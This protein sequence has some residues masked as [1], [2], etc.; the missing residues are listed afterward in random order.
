MLRN[1]HLRPHCL[2]HS[3][4]RSPLALIAGAALACTV[5]T[6]SIQAAAKA[7]PSPQTPPREQLTI[8]P[9]EA[10][11]PWTGDLDGMIER[12]MIRVLTTY[13]R[14]Y[15][16]VEPRIKTGIDSRLGGETLCLSHCGYTSWPCCIVAT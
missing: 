3:P 14:R 10:M 11:K 9:E 12:K 6:G 7:P 2:A 15:A 8:T 4:T 13:S 5:Y 16:E 1:S